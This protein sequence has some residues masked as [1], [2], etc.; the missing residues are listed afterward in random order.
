MR[1]ARLLA[2]L[3]VLA[4]CS[5]CQQAREPGAV[6]L[7]TIDTTRADHLSGYGYELPT[8]PVLDGIARRGV[9]FE[10]AY[11]TMP[12]TDPSHV[13]MLT[14]LYPRTHGVRMNG[15]KMHDDQVDTLA[16][17]FSRRGYDTAAVTA[18]AH[19]SPDDLGLK[20]F[21]FSDVP[22][23]PKYER[24]FGDVLAPVGRWLEKRA[25][26]RWFMWVH[27]WEPHAP[28]RP[29]PLYRKRFAQKF[30][31]SNKP[32]AQRRYS[33]PPT[34]VRKR[35]IPDDIVRASVGLYDGDIATADSALA[36]LV[37]L[38]RLHAPDGSEPM[39]IIASDH[40]ESLAE[41]QA[42]KGIGFGHGAL[43]Y[44]EVV[45]VPW[46]V[47]WEGEIGP[48]VISTPVSLLDMPG[49]I[50][51]F[52]DG[53]RPLL[54][55][56][57]SLAAALSSGEEPVSEPVIIERRVYKKP[58]LRSLR[59]GQLAIVDH[60]WKLIRTAR[61]HGPELYNLVDDPEERSNL[62]EERADVLG[63]LDAALDSWVEGHP[64][65]EPGFSEPAEL[66]K[67]L[68]DLRSL[69]YVD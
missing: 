32:R 64:V 53:G 55:Q 41:R 39:F 21:D 35:L 22:G 30:I 56:G 25:G 31:E 63:R 4:L 37:G 49:T 5:A 20:G 29:A 68:E 40:G 50:T 27:L 42:E 9:R 47:T 45:K 3:F 69:G 16:A 61:F 8:S 13:S 60:P 65:Y 6:M 54:G 33:E 7:I 23:P 10:N 34:Y 66:E 1:P 19:L 18:R 51:G 67:K 38:A 28:Y 14:G 57:R 52:L 43:L 44:D 2:P 15:W 58:P 26:R 24:V 11:C 62:V 36:R 48:A 12:T 46:V 17:W 59:Q